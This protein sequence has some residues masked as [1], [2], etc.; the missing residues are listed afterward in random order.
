MSIENPYVWQILSSNFPFLQVFVSKISCSCFVRNNK[1]YSCLLWQTSKTMLFK[2]WPNTL[3]E[4]YLQTCSL[5]SLPI[6]SANSGFLMSLARAWEKS[7][8]VGSQRN[9]VNPWLIVS[10]GPPL[11]QAITGFWAAIASNGTMPKCSSLQINK[12]PSSSVTFTIWKEQ[13]LIKWSHKKLKK[14]NDYL[15]SVYDTNTFTQ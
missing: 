10:R 4:K 12:H 8:D 2:R 3:V 7:W 15:G 11:L 6:L 5:A 9:P 13:D 1:S 14:S